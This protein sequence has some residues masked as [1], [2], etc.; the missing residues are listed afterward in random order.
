MT[1]IVL[2]CGPASAPPGTSDISLS[3]SVPASAPSSSEKGPLTVQFGTAP[4][5]RDPS[6]IHYVNVLV[7]APDIRPISRSVTVID[8]TAPLIRMRIPNGYGR[9]FSVECCNASGTVLLSGDTIMDLDGTPRSVTIYMNVIDHDTAPPSVISTSPSN[10]SIHVQVDTPVSVQFSEPMAPDTINTTTFLLSGVEGVVQYDQTAQTAVFIPH[11]SLPYETAITAT[12]TTGAT[13]LA[14]NPLENDH[15]WIFMTASAPDID[16]PVIM[17]TYPCD[18]ATDIPLNVMI[19]AYFD[20][21][22]DPAAINTSTFSLEGPSGP[23]AGTVFYDI[24]TFVVR[25]TPDAE[26]LPDSLYTV[27]ARTDMTDL[28]DNQLEQEQVW[29]FRTI[30]FAADTAAPQ[31]TGLVSITVPSYTSMSLSWSPASD[32]VTPASAIVYLVYVSTYPG[33]QD[34]STPVLITPPGATGVVVG[35]LSPGTFYYFVVRARD[36]AGNIDNNTVELA[37]IAQGLYVDVVN[38]SDT[39]GSGAPDDPLR[40]ITAAMSIAPVNET[41]YVAPGTYDSAVESFPIQI[42]PGISLLCLGA[43][44]NTVVSSVG[45]G[46]DTLWGNTGAMISGC[47]IIP[48][49]GKTGITDREG[50]PVSGTPVNMTIQ[51]C[52][53]EENI[54]SLTTTGMLISAD[55]LVRNTTFTSFAGYAM[56]IGSGNTIIENCSF[57]DNSN[58]LAILNGSTTISGTIFNQNMTGL[59]IEGGNPTIRNSTFSSNDRGISIIAGHPLILDNSIF[60][61]TVAGIEITVTSDIPQ[62][63]G[64]WINNNG[65]GIHIIDGVAVIRNNSIYCN[66]ITDLWVSNPPPVDAVNNAWDHD[67]PTIEKEIAASCS[68]AGIDICYNSR[69]PDYIPYYTP[70]PMGC[71]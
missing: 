8:Q 15:V 70:V 60:L 69:E 41:I 34:F 16:P 13:D 65:K 35:G 50:G 43:G 52:I 48:D 4:G 5:P 18:G 54:G 36:E 37:G 11:N 26:L 47:T 1:G 22:M 58:A 9:Q 32:N 33:G 28:A 46:Q 19:S 7:T 57:T 49:A 64:N 27:H 68:T 20:E 63:D 40:S 45:S 59:S 17:N 14:G 39:E 53:I 67:P 6:D 71:E 44:H 55:S 30:P 24:D 56:I 61:N 21:P 3:L 10:G 38:G 51:N 23:V 25:F 12:I 62:I 42:K 66:N 29:S 2:S 31:F